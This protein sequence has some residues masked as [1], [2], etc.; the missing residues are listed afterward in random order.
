M[1]EN[2]GSVCFYDV[3]LILLLS[4]HNFTTFL[5]QNLKKEL[6]QFYFHTSPWLLKLKNI[7]NWPP[8]S[9]D[10]FFFI[11]PLGQNLRRYLCIQRNCKQTPILKQ[12]TSKQGIY[13]IKKVLIIFKRYFRNWFCVLRPPLKGAVVAKQGWNFWSK[14]FRVSE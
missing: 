8:K 4:R 9:W 10:V 5:G 3:R 11:F 2:A 1:Q 14:M 12:D 13:E 6:G 7:Q